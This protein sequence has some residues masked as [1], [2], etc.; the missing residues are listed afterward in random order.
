MVYSEVHPLN[1]VNLYLPRLSQS[2]KRSEFHIRILP[3]VRPSNVALFSHLKSID[4]V[5][6]KDEMGKQEY[7]KKA[8]N[9]DAVG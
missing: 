2:V 5:N 9:I 3:S 8:L 4:I 1:S 7:N 6:C